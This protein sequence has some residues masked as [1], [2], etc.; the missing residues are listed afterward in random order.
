MLALF[1]FGLRLLRERVY[2]RRRAQRDQRTGHG[3][4][5]RLSGRRIFEA[6]C[7]KHKK[8]RQSAIVSVVVR[9]AEAITHL[10][11]A[12]LE[13]T[14][15]PPDGRG[16]APAQS[17]WSDPAAPERPAVN[18]C[19]C[20]FFATTRT[21]LTHLF[22]FLRH[23]GYAIDGRQLVD[24]H[25]AA[26]DVHQHLCIQTLSHTCRSIQIATYGRGIAE[27]SPPP[28]PPLYLLNNHPSVL[29]FENGRDAICSISTYSRCRR[30]YMS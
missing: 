14:E 24:V 23:I 9:R 3:Q 17:D 25:V 27:T 8:H 28:P 19:K 21:S 1:A 6:T 5:G 20:V 12:G 4:T 16:M 2:R 30:R 26:L 22:P 7:G 13:A 10:S 18:R 15:R 11:V 29:T